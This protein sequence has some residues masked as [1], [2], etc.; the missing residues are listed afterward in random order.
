MNKHKLYRGRRSPNPHVFISYEDITHEMI[1]LKHIERHSPDGFEWGYNGS[2][3]ADLA[4]SILND[5]VGK[6]VADQY[7]ME[8]KD[9][10]ISRLPTHSFDFT[11]S[12]VIDWVKEKMNKTSYLGT[13]LE[14]RK[15]I[16]K[17]DCE[18]CKF[19]THEN[20]HDIYFHELDSKGAILVFQHGNKEHEFRTYRLSQIFRILGIT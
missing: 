2:G 8:F 7:Y 17:N 9:E 1:N 10:V 6:E 20:G 13:I 4:L 14:D 3:P 12:F 15:P 5:A 16:F 19:L 11:V 18:G